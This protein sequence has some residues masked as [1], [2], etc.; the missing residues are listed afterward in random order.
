M[1]KLTKKQRRQILKKAA[2]T[3]EYVK[4]HREEILFYKYSCVAV[5]FASWNYDDLDIPIDVE[6]AKYV[7]VDRLGLYEFNG[8]YNEQTQL[9]RQLAVLMFME[10]TS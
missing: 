9:A 8:K 7:G 4:G 3:L 6:Y 2:E 5:A 10:A 1:K